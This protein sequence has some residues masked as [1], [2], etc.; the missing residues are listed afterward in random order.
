MVM[1]RR[2]KIVAAAI[3]AQLLV[4]QDLTFASVS[5]SRAV[6]IHQVVREL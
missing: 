6:T 3:N 4:N 5:G 1:R 2:S